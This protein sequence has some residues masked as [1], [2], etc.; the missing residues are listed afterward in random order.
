ME[1]YR[2]EQLK[3]WPEAKKD[4]KKDGFHYKHSK[5]YGVYEGKIYKTLSKKIELFNQ[6]YAEKKVD[7][8]PVYRARQA[9]PEGKFGLVVGR[10]AYITQGS[11]TNN[12]L[13]SEL[14]PE[15]E[16]WLHPKPARTM[17]MASGEMV[18]V[19]SPVGRGRLKVR[20][21]EEIRPDTVYMDSGF[22]VLSKGLSN[23]FGKGASI[24]EILEDHNDTISGNMAMH[25]TFVTVR[26][27]R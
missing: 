25:E 6:R 7:P 26:K 4:L 17:A 9:V 2:Q 11:S 23:I 8:M 16:L 20:V 1:E 14:V 18:E 27:V 15:N 24:V 10:N 21:T 22:G 12:A 3:D 5:I 19:T 13:L